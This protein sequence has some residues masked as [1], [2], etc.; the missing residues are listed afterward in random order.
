MGLLHIHKIRKYVFE[1]V[2]HTS[3]LEHFE[4]VLY[5]TDEYKCKHVNSLSKW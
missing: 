5:W 3:L 2:V 4:M 1:K